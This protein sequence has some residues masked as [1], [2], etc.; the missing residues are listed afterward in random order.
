MRISIKSLSTIVFEIAVEN[1]DAKSTAL[2]E[3]VGGEWMLRRT[4]QRGS[5]WCASRR[6]DWPEAIKRA[7]VA[8]SNDVTQKEP[9]Q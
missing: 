4:P 1:D 3:K 7:L 5:V 9:K 6:V 8:L 2:L